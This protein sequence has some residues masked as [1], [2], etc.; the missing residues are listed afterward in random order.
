LNQTSKACWDGS[1]AA[2]CNA[3]RALIT[4]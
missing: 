4:A 1:S 3:A 2:S